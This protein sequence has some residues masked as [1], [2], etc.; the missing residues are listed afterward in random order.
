MPEAADHEDE[1]RPADRD[2]QVA[3]TLEPLVAVSPVEQS[4]A[5]RPWVSSTEPES[6]TIGETL[7]A[8]GPPNFIH[9]AQEALPASP[10]PKQIRPA[11]RTW[12]RPEPP[13]QV[14]P[15]EETPAPEPPP[16]IHYTGETLPATEPPDLIHVAGESAP[17][18]EPPNL[19]HPESVR[20]TVVAGSNRIVATGSEPL[21]PSPQLLV[22]QRQ[23]S[24]P[25]QPP[26]APLPAELLLLADPLPPDG[27]HIVPHL[28]TEPQLETPRPAEPTRPWSIPA[29][30]L[31]YHS[32]PPL[33]AATI[34]QQLVP[35][36]VA[37]SVGTRWGVELG[38]VPVVRGRVAGARAKELS[39][40]AFTTRGVVHLPDEA[41]EL[42]DPGVQALLAHE[43][44]HVAQ[45]QLLGADLPAAA[46]AEGQRLE[47]QAIA[48][49][50]W[51]HAGTP[52]VHRPI[53]HRCAEAAGDRTEQ[54]QAAPVGSE[55]T[56]TMPGVISDQGSAPPAPD[57]S[58]L[59]HSQPAHR[60]PVSHQRPESSWPT[61]AQQARAVPPIRAD[62][63]LIERLDRLQE[64]VDE[65]HE[66][67]DRVAEDLVVRLD[68]PWVLG[69]LA[70]R[71]YTNFRHRLRAELLIDR[72][73]HGALA[74]LR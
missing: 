51:F 44:T 57:A 49:E 72:E 24:V 22:P 60:E 30:Q 68:D 4:R 17:V 67:H 36:Q 15:G 20:G 42:T 32:Q 69:R 7:P 35:R 29:V 34:T 63:Q 13:K 54:V 71:L 61:V 37:T 25:P 10:P 23:L 12:P 70:E 31:R 48:T 11:G 52:L 8:P 1:R 39:V 26:E 38:D 65:L 33:P 5:I 9:L 41:G 18:P 21:V 56:W 6:G 43:L 46:S 58:T 53:E 73:R 59:D 47:E 3:P 28:P 74:D 27:S 19:I 64:E 50:Q 16:L 14:H 66:R 2:D 40:R 62:P 45:Q 55:L